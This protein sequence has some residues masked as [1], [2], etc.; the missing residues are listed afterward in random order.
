MIGLRGKE[1][2]GDVGFWTW[3]TS[4]LRILDFRF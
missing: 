3:F 2:G 4:P 1:E